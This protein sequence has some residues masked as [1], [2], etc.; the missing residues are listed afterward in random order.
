MAPLPRAFCWRRYDWTAQE[1]VVLADD[2]GLHAHSTVVATRTEL[3]DP[4]VCRYKLRTD[5]AWRSTDLWVES[6]GAGWRRTLR[7]ER[8]AGS[9]RITAAEEGALDAPS[10][11]AERPDDILDDIDDA[12]DVDLTCTLLTNTLPVRRLRLLDPSAGPR[13]M[14]MA[15]VSVPDLVVTPS[16]QTYTPLGG[17]RMGFASDGFRADLTLD[18]DGY[19]LDYPGIG[20]RI[21]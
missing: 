14:L 8:A 15:W 9:W 10:P 19:V 18:A 3:G 7:L 17:P 16:Q 13:T 5:P 6:E 21:W 20:E 4:W 12:T 11:G 1:I 2:D